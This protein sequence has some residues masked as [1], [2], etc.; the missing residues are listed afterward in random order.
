VRCGHRKAEARRTQ[1]YPRCDNDK[2][3]HEILQRDDIEVVDI[4]AHPAQ[5][6]P[7]IEA[8]LHAGKHVLSQKPFVLDLSTGEKLVDLAEEKNLKLA[9]NQNGRWAPHFAYMRQAL[10]A[11]VIGEVASVDFGVQ[12]N[13]N[14]IERH[15]VRLHTPHCAL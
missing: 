5:R 11:G 6:A 4:A 8:A 3:L 15:A 14:W 12:W 13:H 2:R 10:A 1:F 9:V 7:L